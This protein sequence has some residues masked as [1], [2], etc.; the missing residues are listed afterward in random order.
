MF[1]VAT[2]NLR[3]ADGRIR[4]NTDDLSARTIDA[5]KN[6]LRQQLE[7]QADQRAMAALVEK[8]A[9]QATIQQ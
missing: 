7:A 2:K 5:A 9:A 8:L 1:D 4:M 6:V 3:E